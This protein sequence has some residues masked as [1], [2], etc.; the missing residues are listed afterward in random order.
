MNIS[1]FKNKIYT[2]LSSQRIITDLF[3]FLFRNMRESIMI[4]LN[5]I[6]IKYIITRIR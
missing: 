4:F 2:K 5:L 3:N 1:Y 6:H